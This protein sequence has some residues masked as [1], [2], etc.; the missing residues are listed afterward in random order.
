[1]IPHRRA[2]AGRAALRHAGG[3]PLVF[4]FYFRRA[5]RRRDSRRF[6]TQLFL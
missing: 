2:G 1:M 6:D 5:T 4:A 3:F